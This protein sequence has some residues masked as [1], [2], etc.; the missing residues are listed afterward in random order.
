MSE[1]IRDTFIH[2]HSADLI[3]ELRAEVSRIEPVVAMA[4]S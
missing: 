4:D 2:L 3:G 1:Q